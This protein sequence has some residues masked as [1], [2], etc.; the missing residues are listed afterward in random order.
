KIAIPSTPYDAKGLLKTAIRG[1]DP[2]LF[3]EHKMLYFTK[4]LVPEEEYLIPFG[5]ADVKK[6]GKD[7]TIVA[8][9][10]MVQKALKAADILAKEGIEAE[11]IDPRTLVPFDKQTIINSVKKTGRIV[12]VTEENKRGASSAEIASIIAEEAWSWLKAPI[13]RIGAPNTPVPFSPPLENYY[14]PNEEKIIEA[15]KELING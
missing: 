15:V 8:T 3:L 14:I 13:K 10:A 5:K 6:E 9:L 7:I 2:V 12:I 11:V 4:G 1:D